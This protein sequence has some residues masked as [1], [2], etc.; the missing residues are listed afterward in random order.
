MVG[1]GQRGE[2]EVI[3]GEATSGDNPM[4]L[5]PRVVG[6]LLIY[7]VGSRESRVQLTARSYR[8]WT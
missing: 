2:M 6:K 3:A 8:V 5:K 1:E 7:G 4:D